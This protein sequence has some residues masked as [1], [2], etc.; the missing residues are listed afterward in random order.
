MILGRVIRSVQGEH[1]S[2]ISPLRL[3]RIFVW[4]DVI[5]FLTQ[6][7]G[8]SLQAMKRFNPKTAEYVVLAG[9]GIQIFIFSVFIVVAF[10]WHSRMNK[11]PT[12]VSSTDSRWKPIM[13]MLYGASILIMVRSVFRI[14]EYAMGREAY[15]LQ[16][17]WTMYVF[18]SALMVITVAVFAWWYPGLL[19]GPKKAQMM[20][21]RASEP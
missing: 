14:I 16:N 5:S 12:A 2:P 20:E 19:R 21:E 8:G 18:D 9:L 10:T 11:S 13:F 6:V 4:G 17:E 7:I 3:T 1:H 15:L